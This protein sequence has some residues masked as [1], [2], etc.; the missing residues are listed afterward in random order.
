MS[1]AARSMPDGWHG[2]RLVTSAGDVARVLADVNAAGVRRDRTA[3]MTQAV[4]LADDVAL[5]APDASRV[6]PVAPELGGLLPWAGGLRRGATV[7]V[8]NSASLLL[9]LL[10]DANVA[11][12][13]TVVVGMP[14]FGV[15]AAADFGIDLSRLAL[16]PEPGPDWPTVVSACLEGVDLVVVNTTAPVPDATARALTARARRSGA[17]LIP[18]RLEVLGGP[19]TAAPWAGA[20]LVLERVEQRWVGLGSGHGRLRRQD[21]V[22]RATGRG[23]STQPRLV[24]TTLPPPSIVARVP[25]QP[26]EIPEW[27]VEKAV[28]RLAEIEAGLPT[29]PP[30]P[31]PVGTEP[32]PFDPWAELARRARE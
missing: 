16:I 28:A 19:A 6:L 21:V 30:T 11:G 3:A 15:L 25:R 26:G 13:W 24:T 20:D 12:S 9:T 23:R 18:T 4:R 2:N 32:K 14:A 5:T 10:A 7:A 17:V 27:T 29:S 1:Q 8:A 31:P 22:L